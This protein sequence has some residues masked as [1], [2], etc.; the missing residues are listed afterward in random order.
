MKLPAYYNI[1]LFIIILNR[2]PPRPPEEGIQTCYMAGAEL[3]V[4]PGWRHPAAV[5]QLGESRPTI[6]NTK[7][8]VSSNPRLMRVQVGQAHLNAPK[9]ELWVSIG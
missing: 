7:C 1:N 9:S 4:W 8:L 3:S 2:G 5:S 6:W